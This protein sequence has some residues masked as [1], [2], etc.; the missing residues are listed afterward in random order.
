M[1]A[2]DSI[3]SAGLSIIDKVI[4]DPVKKAEAKQKLL[5]LQQKGELSEIESKMKIIVAEAQSQSW[6]ARNWRPLVMLMFAAVIFNNYILA[7]WLP[8]F[9]IK[10][11]VIEMPKGMWTLLQL[12]IGGYIAGRSTEKAIK[13][14]KE[15]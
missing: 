14:W 10:F 11:A 8:L 12:G 9:G 1:L 7:A 3:I 2:I 6:I 5:E 15:K 4:P 13:T